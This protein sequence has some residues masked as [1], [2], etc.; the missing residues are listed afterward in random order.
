MN[1]NN[2]FR[3]RSLTGKVLAV[4]VLSTV[5][6]TLTVIPVVYVTLKSGL[7]GQ[8]HRHLLGVKHLVERLIEDNRRTVRNY[9]LLFSSDRQ[10]K[11]NLYYFAELAGERIHPL[12]AINHLAATFD[13]Q[14]IELGDRYGRVVANGLR[15]DQHDRD[16][17]ND[18]LVRSAL[19]GKEVTGI[20]QYGDGFLLRA[21]APIYH[22]ESQ[23]IGTISTGM[24]MN[25]DFAR[26]IKSLS[27]VEILIVDTENRIV[28][29][30][31]EDTR[32]G[33]RIPAGGDTAIGSTPYQVMH[34]PFD[35]S[36]GRPLGTV[37]IMAEDSTVP[38]L[39][40]AGL[41]VVMALLAVAVLSI[42]ATILILR[43]VL[44]PV[45]ELRLGAEKIGSGDFRH[46][47]P[48]T[49][50]DEIGSLAD[51]FNKMAANLLKMREVEEK[52]QH[53]QRLASIGEFTAATAHELNNPIANIIGLLKVMRREIPRDHELAEDLDMVVREAAR[54]GAIVRDLLMYSRPSRPNK[55]PVEL[56]AL[57]EESLD[58]VEKRSGEEHKVRFRFQRPEQPV[59]VQADPYQ[60]EQVLRNLLLN[61]RQAIEESGEITVAVRTDEVRRT[62]EVDVSDT[63]CGIPE[64]NIGRIFYPFFTT[65]KSG[66]GTGLG[67]A[68]S[69][70][71]MQSHGGDIRVASRVGEGSVF[72]LS[73]PRGENSE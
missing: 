12:N 50:T 4:I 66:E 60:L 45:S 44:T 49:S 53:S 61:A 36:A 7:Q 5:A 38:V 9:A 13:L 72:T 57:I 21:V 28:A 56:T 30:T 20:E 14:F 59:I 37:L 27:G 73:L 15:P 47:I 51:V 24:V 17:S 29:S 64:E 8:R 26:V 43:R 22:D 62:V 19:A 67:L 39:R 48:V 16:K 11:D 40:K 25:N 23:L 46:R 69:Y 63:G 41:N 54:C 18:I 10:V 35:D 3:H 6:A 58:R 42:G 33:E 2:P 71:V 1:V 68:V 34:L 65:K 70:A 55:E 31:R 32:P 52:L